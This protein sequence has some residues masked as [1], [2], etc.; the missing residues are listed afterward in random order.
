VDTSKDEA[1]RLANVV[2][3]ELG[4]SPRPR[5][6]AGM[7]DI[8]D[9]CPLARTVRAEA[10]GISVTV[11]GSEIA[12]WV[13][14]LEAAGEPDHTFEMTQGGARFIV[15]FDLGRYPELVTEPGR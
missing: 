1:L 8:P 11:G 12:V 2:R 7:R 6:T 3:R 10:E 5:L 4:L 15:D 9:H 14:T 13:G